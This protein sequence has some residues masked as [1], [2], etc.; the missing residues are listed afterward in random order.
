[1]G[2][3]TCEKSRVPGFFC[4]FLEENPWYQ[5]Y[6]EK[7]SGATPPTKAHFF[8]EFR[9]LEDMTLSEFCMTL[10]IRQ[11]RIKATKPPE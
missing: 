10:E 9:I 3:A 7:F 2:G 8:A 6:R 1:M 5:D 4:F 11:G